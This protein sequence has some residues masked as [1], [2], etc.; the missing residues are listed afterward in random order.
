MPISTKRSA[1]GRHAASVRWQ[2]D[3]QIETARDLAA[4]RIEEYVERVV[5]TAPPLTDEQAA[6]I[7]RLL[8]LE[9]SDA[10]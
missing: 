5:S 1:L 4:A 9:R 6:R 2:R 10:A 3:D 7:V 8:G